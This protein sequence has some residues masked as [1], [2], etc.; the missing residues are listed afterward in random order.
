LGQP[1]F[2]Q[3][4]GGSLTGGSIVGMI[5]RQALLPTLIGAVIRS[6]MYGASP[7]DAGAFGAATLLMLGV[8]LLVSW[9]PARHA[10]RVDP[11]SV[12]RQE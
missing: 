1:R 2:A 4:I 5:I 7:V 8:M 3:R 12:L 9:I 10:G 6:R 11:I